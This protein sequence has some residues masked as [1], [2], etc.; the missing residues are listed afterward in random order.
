[1]YKLFVISA[2]VSVSF[3]AGCAAYQPKVAQEKT[4]TTKDNQT[5][6][7]GG[8]YN[9]KK[10]QLMVS[11]NGESIMRGITRPLD[12]TLNLNA[13]YNNTSVSSFCY[14]G[15]VLQSE[16][17]AFG[18]IAG[19]VQARKGKSGDTCELKIEGEIVGKLYF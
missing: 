4:V 3:F 5:F 2:L 14:L 16:G 1:M 12:P 17:G 19:A 8:I 6:V 13:E 11:V 18:M 9:E 7:F 15:S 10:G